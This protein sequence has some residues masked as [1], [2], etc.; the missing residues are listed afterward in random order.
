ME[1]VLGQ[2]GVINHQQISGVHDRIL[3]EV[4]PVV[5]Y[6]DAAGPLICAE[7][8][9]WD[10]FATTLHVRNWDAQLVSLFSHLPGESLVC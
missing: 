9:D 3:V 2:V 7:V 5:H 1:A 6:P 4:D 10:V 8:G